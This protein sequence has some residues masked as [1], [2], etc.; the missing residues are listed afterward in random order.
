MSKQID[1]LRTGLAAIT[2]TGAGAT[3]VLALLVIAAVFVAIVTPRA[4]LSYR[5]K[6]LRQL[7][8]AT[9]AAQ[10]TVI[11]TVDLP[12]LGGALGP[13]GQPIFGDMTG[14]DFGPIGAELT[15]HLRAEGLPIDVRDSWWGVST[16][17]IEAPGAAKSAYNGSTPPVVQLLDRSDLGGNGTLVE[18][19]LPATESLQATSATFQVAVTTA[20]AKR[21]GLLVGSTVGLTD[22]DTGA[23]SRITLVVT[24]ILRPVRQASAFWQVDPNALRATFN[25][26]KFGGYWLGTMFVGDS[27]IAAIETAITDQN[28]AVNWVDAVRLGSISVGQVPA[29]HTA[30]GSGL[31][32]A[33]VVTKSVA[34]PLTVPLF[35]AV[36]ATLGEYLQT[37]S[38]LASLLSLLYVSLTVVGLVVL[39]LGARLLAER[40]AR[41][42]G[43]IRA[44][45][46]GR[47]QLA[48]FAA[49]A[50]AIAVIP[51]AIIGVLLGVLLTPGQDD[52]T[53]WWL[54]AITAAAALVAVPWLAMRRAWGTGLVDERADSIPSRTVRA[55]RLVADAAAVIAS[56][57]GLIVLRLQ[58]P[59]PPGGTDWYTSAAPVL[60]AIPLAIVVVRV[61]PVVLTWLVGLAGRRRGV[62]SFVGLAR[63]TRSASGAALPAF[64]LV[65]ALGVIAFGAMLRTAVLG[66]DI[67]QSWRAVG[68]DAVVDASYANAPVTP[69]TLRAIRAVPGVQW[70]APV[71]VENAVTANGTTLGL[72]VVTP[73][74]YAAMLAETPAERFP[75]GLLAQRPGGGPQAPVPAL[76]SPGAATAI[77]T[78]KVLAGVAQLP[79]H[80]VGSIATMPGIPTT[81]PFI[82]VPRWAIDRT[83]KSG[84]YAP[85]LVLIVGPVDKAVLAAVVKRHLPGLA[86]I[87]YRSTVLSQLT[88]AALPRGAY[89]TLAQGAAAAAGFGAIIM[90][91]ML[92]LGARPRELT[93]ARLFTMGLSRRQARL[94][95]ITEAL[96]ALLAA[97]AGGAVCA[98]ALVPLIGPSINLSPFTGVAAAVPLRADFPVIGY[99]SGCL[100]LLALGTL[101]GQVAVTRLRGVSRAL[102]VGE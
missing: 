25:K 51:A 8:A 54:A 84:R 60:V 5:D 86:I 68:A 73:Q 10:R 101:F 43:L 23:V 16:G 20:T 92:A 44:R 32:S 72:I 52:P 21:F 57:G 81:G 63:A 95:V 34:T 35:A 71:T 28:M 46:A 55:R 31:Q 14:T 15:R 102:R 69:A 13:L 83:V 22:T 80:V 99:L 27:E 39:M 79:I 6:A 100:V 3:A 67:A 77:G 61:Y 18:G 74:S 30:L 7:I 38:Q 78:K 94:V 45:G 50:G 40:R 19:H 53:G 90:A 59:P 96:P 24:G 26:T 4:S 42:L 9:P 88:G 36:T 65:L 33:G 58:G 48:F 12:T 62:T 64:A 29:I 37:Q 85:D 76:A 93:L 89:A 66:G 82:V 41:E 17:F 97:T 56:I 49:R 98:W 70:A 11:G 91:I 2:G 75:A 47:G 1:R 87:S